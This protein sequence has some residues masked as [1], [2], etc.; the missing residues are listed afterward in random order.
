[1]APLLDA[2]ASGELI[3]HL[4]NVVVKLAEGSGTAIDRRKGDR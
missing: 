1:M 4:D 3:P 2:K